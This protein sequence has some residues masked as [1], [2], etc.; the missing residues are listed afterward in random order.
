MILLL[1][2]TSSTSPLA[3]GLARAGYR[4]LVSKATDVPLEVGDHAGIETRWGPLDEEGLAALVAARQIRAIVD[5]THPYASLIRATAARVARAMAVP[6]LSFSRG[7]AVAPDDSSVQWVADHAAAAAAAFVPRRP[8]LLTTGARHLAPYVEESRRT[9][10]RLVARVLD[11]PDSLA[12]CRQAGLSPA[13]VIT[14]RGP[15]SLEENLRQIRRFE[16]GVLVTKDSGP[17]GGTREKLRAA[18]AAGCR[19]IVI[20]RPAQ[21]D[22]GSFTDVDALVAELARLVG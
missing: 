12:S 5:A 8:V 13:Q 21:A 2:G 4:V 16:I 6:Y 11:H 9:G 17:A 22:A 3:L 1:G 7:S 10:V 19:V 18:E 14:G 15:Y 20:A